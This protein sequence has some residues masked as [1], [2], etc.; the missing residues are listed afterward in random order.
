MS[1]EAGPVKLKA[2][3]PQA[4]PRVV[5]ILGSTGSIGVS[6][7]DLIR[8]ERDRFQVAALTARTR[9][10]DLVKQAI[11]FQ[12][13]FVAIGDEAH[14]DNVRDALAS[15][16][17]EVGVGDSAVREAAARDADWVM[18]AIVGSAGLAPTLEAARR[19]A[20]IALANKEC[21][22]CAGDFFLEQAERHGATLLPVDSEHNAIFQVLDAT[23]PETVEKLILTASG[24]PFRSAS[25]EAMKCA[26]PEQAVAH[27][28]WSMGAKISVDS[29]TM[30][31]KGLEVIEA[32]YLFNMAASRI[33]VL[34]HPESI[35]HSLVAYID[36]SVL[37][38][39]GTPD[40]RTPI[41]YALAW[42]TRMSTPSKRLDLSSI[43]ALTFEQ[44]DLTR[45][46][47]LALAR[48]CL[49]EGA[50]TPTVLNAANEVAV[51]AFL[52]RRIGFLDIVAMVR[53]TIE[54]MGSALRGRAPGRLEDIWALDEEARRQAGTIIARRT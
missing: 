38:Q 20:T 32:A 47:A 4:P 34:V 25:F 15:Y 16:D 1:I 9:W 48:D 30:M 6:T 27:P 39:L 37:A 23:R 18:A 49:Q 11:E 50:G 46:P 44:P 45:F 22:V 54:E 31:N 5:S 10:Q 26:T 2:K 36:G 51:E 35:V 40:M 41:S 17:I 33:D 21:L 52:D 43:G 12:P 19:G 14:G 29:A 42:P 24:G 8:G 28:R 3:R 53:E 7:L 13:E